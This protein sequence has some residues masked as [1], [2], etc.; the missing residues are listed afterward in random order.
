MWEIEFFTKDNGRCP[1]TEFLDSLNKKTD[2]P[3]INNDLNQLAEHGF[4]LKRPQVGTLG[5]GLYE[6]RTKTRNGQFRF[7]YF[8][9]DKEIIVVTH[10]FPK[11]TKAI[12]PSEIKL[13]K[14]YRQ[15]Y[16]DRKL[17]KRS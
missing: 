5:D 2:L 10:G 4:N 9:F 6:L 12:N 17:G 11:K 14:E 13:A 16:F 7:I 15:I 8:F 1:A 3:Y